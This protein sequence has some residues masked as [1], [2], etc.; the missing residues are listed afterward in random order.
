MLYTWQK[1]VLSLFSMAFEG[2]AGILI[3]GVGK[4]GGKGDDQGAEVD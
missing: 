2:G 1:E 3:Y 4:I